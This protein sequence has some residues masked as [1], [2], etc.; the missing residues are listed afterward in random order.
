MAGNL[1]DK[2]LFRRR[3]ESGIGSSRFKKK[4][5]YKTRSRERK[6]EDKDGSCNSKS[7]IIIFCVPLFSK[8]I[9][10]SLTFLY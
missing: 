6:I 8:V 3:R 2:F 1:A 4:G 5:F 7:V 9:F 10:L